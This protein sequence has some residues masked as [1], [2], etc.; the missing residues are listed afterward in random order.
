MKGMKILGIAVFMVVMTI[1]ST[2][3]SHEMRAK[4]QHNPHLYELMLLHDGFTFFHSGGD[5]FG[6]Q[7]YFKWQYAKVLQDPKTSI[8]TK[9]MFWPVGIFYVATNPPEK[10]AFPPKFKD[11]KKYPEMGYIFHPQKLPDGHYTVAE[12]FSGGGAVVIQ[13]KAGKY[14]DFVYI[15]RNE[16]TVRAPIQAKEGGRFTVF[17]GKM[18]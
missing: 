6:Y 7:N 5:S 17:Q 8:L 18:I 2:A 15:V 11:W 3:F 13:H 16:Y 9:I 4:A 12:V 1:V 10:Y 14:R